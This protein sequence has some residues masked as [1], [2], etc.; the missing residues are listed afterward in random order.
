MNSLKA[1]KVYVRYFSL[2]FQARE[3]L[4]KFDTETVNTEVF[5]VH[6]LRLRASPQQLHGAIQLQSMN[7][8][9]V[10]GF[11]SAQSSYLDMKVLTFAEYVIFL[12]PANLSYHQNC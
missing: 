4:L 2:S 10:T 7:C 3:D 11:Y 8:T 1:T 5:T 12:T 6:A 9:W